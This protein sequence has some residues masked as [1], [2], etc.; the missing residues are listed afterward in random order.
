MKEQII[1]KSVYIPIIGLVIGIFLIGTNYQ[2]KICNE[3]HTVIW[4]MLSHVLIAEIIGIL[5]IAIK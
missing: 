1:I 5:I 4:M 3:K 2:D